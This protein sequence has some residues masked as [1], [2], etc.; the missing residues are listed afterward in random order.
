MRS[1]ANIRWHGVALL[2]VGILLGLRPPMAAAEDPLGRAIFLSKGCAICHEERAVL[3]APHISVLRKDRSFFELAAGMWN[4]A[5]MMWANLPEPGLRWPR[6]TSREMA[7]LAV[8]LDGSSPKDPAPNVGQGQLLLV[9]KGCLACHTAD[10]QGQKTAK[11]LLRQ[12]RLDSN[13]AW[14]AALWNHAPSML[15]ARVDT[16]REYPHLDAKDIADMVGFLRRTGR[17]R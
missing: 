14:A 6:L 13:E 3:Q 4:H 11:D 10:G 15:A 1:A 5:P 7:D 9:E 12:V 16:A 2:A 17:G 8:Y